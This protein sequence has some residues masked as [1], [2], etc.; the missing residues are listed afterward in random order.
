NHHYSDKQAKETTQYNYDGVSGALQGVQFADGSRAC[1]ETDLLGRPV[2][3]TRL[4]APGAP[5]SAQPIAKVMSF[6]TYA[7][8]PKFQTALTPVVLDPGSSVPKT[9]HL[10][11]DAGRLAKVRVQVDSNQADVTEY[12]YA[13]PEPGL[14]HQRFRLGYQTWA[15]TRITRPDGTI[16][17]L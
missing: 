16:V 3:Q 4:P 8:D 5:G 10:D 11:W 14:L 17:H 2:Q 15:P 9:M 6:G 1:V 7:G 12:A 13:P